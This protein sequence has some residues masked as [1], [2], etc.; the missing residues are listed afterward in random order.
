MNDEL[1]VLMVLFTTTIMKF[2]E[3]G[4]KTGWT[5]IIIPAEIAQQLKPGNKRSFRVKGF[6]D[7]YQFEGISLLPKGGGDFIM[8]LNATIRKSIR[9]RKGA[10][11]LVNMEP[12]QQPLQ[13]P[14]W[15]TECLEYEPEALDFFNKLPKSH[16]NYFIKWIE[17]AKTE[18]TKTKRIAQTVTALSKR[19][20]F[21]E[22]IRTN[23]D[24]GLPD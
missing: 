5:Y 14:E 18:P 20:G 15:L 11:L 23:R 22:M 3:Q 6:L 21:G 13:R 19:L 4:D 7:N 9:K 17:S 1:F 12:D 2:D 24:T 16:Q 8:P 10:M